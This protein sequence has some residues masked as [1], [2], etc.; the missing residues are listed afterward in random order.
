[1]KRS[2]IFPFLQISGAMIIVG[3]D[4]V[5][6][7]LI[8]A[9]FP[10]FLA[11]T[12]R[13]A[14]ASALLLPL[15]LGIEKRWPRVAKRDLCLILLLSLFGNFLYSIFL[16][17]GLRLTSASEGGMIS[18]TAPIVTAALSYV[19]LRERPG[20]KTI[21]G[22]LLA[23]LGMIVISVG[24]TASSGGTHSLLGDMLIGGSVIGEALWTI[25]GK[26]VSRNVSPL[27]LTALTTFSGFLFFLPCGIVQAISFPLQ[28]LPVSNW[29]IIVYYGSVGTVG[30]Y[31][32][33]YQGIPKV[34]ASTAGM[35]V[36]IMPVSAVLLSYV[37]LKEPFQWTHALGIVCVLAALFC[38]TGK[39]GPQKRRPTAPPPEMLSM[40]TKE[41]DQPTQGEIHLS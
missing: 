10:V 36:G 27:A 40:E 21:S 38:L 13:F 32:L 39:T 6:G 14:L 3:S 11:S 23:I 5:A 8:S 35:F 25:L 41:D 28:S 34:P 18:G 1:M 12:L 37:F 16:L 15:V 2:G 9:G 30:A 22:L 26:T 33:W 17:Y 24:K 20:R 31:L 29:L 7:K 19:F 4:I